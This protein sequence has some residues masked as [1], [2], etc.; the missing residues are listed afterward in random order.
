MK[1]KNDDDDSA[2]GENLVARI[3]SPVL[4]RARELNPIARIV[5]TGGERKVRIT[6]SPF[7]SPPVWMRVPL[8][9]PIPPIGMTLS[10]S[11]FLATVNA[12]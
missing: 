2:I 12:P 8:G 7:L 10:F 5:I 3:L 9:E 4:E 11:S 1:S 6:R